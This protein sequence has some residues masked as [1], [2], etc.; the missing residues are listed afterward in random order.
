ME[1]KK[2]LIWQLYP[3]YLLI[4]LISL[5]AVSWYASNSLRDFY[6][7]QFAA[8]LETRARLLEAQM[9]Q[10]MSSSDSTLIDRLCKQIGKNAGTRISVMLPNGKVIGDSEKD[11]ESMDSHADRPEVID[12]SSGYVG[13]ATRYSRTTDQTMMYIAIP[14]KENAG[15]KGVLRASLPLD[16][17]DE[18]IESIQIKIILGGFFIALIASVVCLYISRR[19][20]R[21]IEEIKQGAEHFAKG[22]LSYRLYTPEIKEMASLA[23]AMNYMAEQLESR[24]QIITTQRN[25]T[26]SILASMTEGVIITDIQQ[27]IIN[28]NQA[29]LK[30]LQRKTFEIKNKS[31]Q[32]V[33]RNREIQNFVRQTL[34]AGKTLQGDIVW[35]NNDPHSVFRASSTPLYGA[36]QKLTGAL[37]VLNDVTRHIHTENIRCDVSMKKELPLQT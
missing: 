29:A 31:I 11:P 32:E 5:A 37:I 13:R 33:I 23:Q 25:E 27:R 22:R 10:G 12:A 6:I 36:D 1:K 20:S 35:H 30:M 18:R 21:P 34:E 7:N 2:R 17:I 8:D 4:I 28:I 14:L 16:F 26:E 9:L 19:I 15:I 3:S 24:I